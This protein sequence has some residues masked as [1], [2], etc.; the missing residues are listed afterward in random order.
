MAHMEERNASPVV[1][2]SK[3]PYEA[4]AATYVPLKLEERLFGSEGP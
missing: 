2:E 4:P 3:A 1:P